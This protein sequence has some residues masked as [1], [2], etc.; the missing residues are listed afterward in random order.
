LGTRWIRRTKARSVLWL[1]RLRKGYAI[2]FGFAFASTYLAT[3]LKSTQGMDDISPEAKATYKKNEGNLAFQEE[4]Y[5]QAAVFYTEALV[6]SPN[7][8]CY[9]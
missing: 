8:I 5:A 4:N 6:L 2:I 3:P 9:R 7:A 1:L